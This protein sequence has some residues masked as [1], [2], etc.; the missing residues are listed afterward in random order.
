MFI[1]QSLLKTKAILFFKV[2]FHQAMKKSQ[3]IFMINIMD[4][5]TFIKALSVNNLEIK[6]LLNK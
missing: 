4:I 2:I 5:Q 1:I 6:K 3:K